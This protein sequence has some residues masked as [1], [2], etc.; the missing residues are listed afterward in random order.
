MVDQNSKQCL[1]KLC[2]QRGY[3]LHISSQSSPNTPAHLTTWSVTLSI[4]GISVYGEGQNKKLATNDAALKMLWRVVLPIEERREVRVRAPPSDQQVIEDLKAKNADLRA[5]I[6]A[7]EAA[8]VPAEAP[9]NVPPTFN[10]FLL[11]L[12]SRREY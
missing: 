10:P 11:T 4:E 7:L 2:K 9:A 12:L 6:E 3:T 5:R 1:D 8:S